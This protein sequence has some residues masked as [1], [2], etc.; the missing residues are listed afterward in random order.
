MQIGKQRRR[1]AKLLSQQSVF[2]SWP[3][4][5]AVWFISADPGSWVIIS[6]GKPLLDLEQQVKGTKGPGWLA[7]RGSW[8]QPVAADWTR[9]QAGGR[10]PGV[11]GRRILHVVTLWAAQSSGCVMSWEKTLPRDWSRVPTLGRPERRL[12]E[13]LDSAGSWD[14]QHSR[15]LDREV[16]GMDV[17][18]S[19]S[20][21]SCT[22]RFCDLEQ[23]MKLLCASVSSPIE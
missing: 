5:S 6:P 12:P 15:I 17:W 22:S 19:S 20:F 14:S 3:L 7:S 21:L 16:K 1:E 9:Q 4:C 8:P 10:V 23:V 18:D 11:H 2:R 13:R